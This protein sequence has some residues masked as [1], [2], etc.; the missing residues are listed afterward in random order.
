MLRAERHCDELLRSARRLILS[1]LKEAPALML[2]NDLA[3]TLELASDR[4]LAAG[5]ALR[6]VAFNRAGASA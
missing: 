2:A 6:E 3:V 4:L 5:Y 1:T